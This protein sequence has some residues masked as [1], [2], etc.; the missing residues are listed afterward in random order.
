M[1][2]FTKLFFLIRV[3][4]A[5]QFS[6]IFSILKNYGFSFVCNLFLSIRIDKLQ[7]ISYRVH[8]FILPYTV[9]IKAQS[10]FRGDTDIT[11]LSKPNDHTHCLS[12]L[13][14]VFPFPYR[15]FQ[16]SLS[17][18]TQITQPYLCDLIVVG[19]D[20]GHP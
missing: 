4:L 15:P 13:V 1:I 11:V 18:N 16:N 8:T 3:Q 5:F 12:A 17:L 9:E 7:I 6:T 20:S 14:H 19:G 10:D 2:Y